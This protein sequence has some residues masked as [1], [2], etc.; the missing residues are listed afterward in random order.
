[1][2]LHNLKAQKLTKKVLEEGLLQD[3][4]PGSDFHEDGHLT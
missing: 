3:Q 2:V 1:M 4:G